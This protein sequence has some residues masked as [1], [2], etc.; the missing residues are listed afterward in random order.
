MFTWVGSVRSAGSAIS[1]RVIVMYQHLVCRTG[2]GIIIGTRTVRVLYEIGAT[3]DI[4]ALPWWWPILGSWWLPAKLPCTH[5]PIPHARIHRELTQGT[6]I[7]MADVG[8]SSSS[9]SR[10]A[11]DLGRGQQEVPL[12]IREAI[13]SICWVMRRRKP[14]RRCAIRCSC[15]CSLMF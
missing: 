5:C 9:G 2:A 10:N 4:T 13:R 3:Y 11:D 6:S 15:S 14:A 7:R 12:R 8:G 1:P